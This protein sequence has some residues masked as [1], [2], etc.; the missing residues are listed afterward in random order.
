M[1]SE[2][3]AV[4]V[5]RYEVALLVLCVLVL[6]LVSRAQTNNE[7]AE[8]AA[9]ALSVKLYNDD[10]VTLPSNK[11][12][13]RQMVIVFTA[14][15]SALCTLTIHRDGVSTW[16]IVGLNGEN[17]LNL[18][19]TTYYTIPLDSMSK[20][21]IV[22]NR[23]S[24][25][26]LHD[27]LIGSG[28]SETRFTYSEDTAVPLANLNTNVTPREWSSQSLPPSYPTYT[29]AA[30]ARAAIA[31]LAKAAAACSAGSSTATP[32]ATPT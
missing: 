3:V 16:P 5:R 25:T 30:A 1:S 11:R 9:T 32:A 17:K 15:A 26:H 13:E 7:A 19:D 8:D 22:S 6:P 12:N 14:K 24:T 4:N 20:G 28:D 31:A 2:T 18:G 27:P 21:L 23:Q 29:T 10:V